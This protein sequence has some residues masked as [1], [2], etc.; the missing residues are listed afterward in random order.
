MIT[1]LKASIIAE[2]LSF[3]IGPERFFLI[4]SIYCLMFVSLVLQLRTPAD[5][6]PY[7]RTLPVNEV[8]F[9]RYDFILETTYLAS[10]HLRLTDTMLPSAAGQRRSYEHVFKYVY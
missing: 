3:I 2:L 5:L 6:Q 4:S 10:G 8:T 1:S 9:I 7:C